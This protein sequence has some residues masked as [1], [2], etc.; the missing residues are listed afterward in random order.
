[1]RTPVLRAESQSDKHTKHVMASVRQ[2]WLRRIAVSTATHLK[3]VIHSSK[4]Y[5]QNELRLSFRGIM[6][7]H[8]RQVITIALLPLSTP[9]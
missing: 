1:M 3:H 9:G 7:G 2:L 4:N 5:S 6:Y 8:Q